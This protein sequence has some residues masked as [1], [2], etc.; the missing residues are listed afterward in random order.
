MDKY[1]FDFKLY[2][3]IYTYCMLY[4]S[5]A[6]YI[7]KSGHLKVV[8]KLHRDITKYFCCLVIISTPQTCHGVNFKHVL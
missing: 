2:V 1:E 6:L 7:F 4:L 5:V 8:V 3:Y